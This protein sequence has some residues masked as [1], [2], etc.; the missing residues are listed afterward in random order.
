MIKHECAA[1]RYLITSPEELAGEEIT[2]PSCEEI[3]IVPYE[4]PNYQEGDE[5]GGEED[6]QSSLFT[7]E[8]HGNINKADAEPYHRKKGWLKNIVAILIGIVIGIFLRV[9]LTPNYVPTLIRELSKFPVL[10]S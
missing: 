4:E 6:T 9:D 1:C 5:D 10:Y 8:E 3:T 7:S 2:C